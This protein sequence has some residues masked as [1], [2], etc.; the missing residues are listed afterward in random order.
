MMRI[1]VIGYLVIGL[2][3]VLMHVL[4]GAGDTIPPMIFS[5]VI[6]WGVQLPL[7]IFL[8]KVGDLGVYG[9]RWAMLSEFV[10]GAVAFGLYFYTGRWK[11]KK[12]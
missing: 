4:P 5:L 2:P 1:A 7:V 3:I 9:V 6:G 11:R 10:L 8:R 12:V